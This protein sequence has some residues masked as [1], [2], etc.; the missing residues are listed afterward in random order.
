MKSTSKVTIASFA[1]L[2]KLQTRQA[3]LQRSSSFANNF[4]LIFTYSRFSDKFP[5][6]YRAISND[7]LGP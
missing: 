5:T 2:H 6:R 7:A 4:G 1:I 3:P